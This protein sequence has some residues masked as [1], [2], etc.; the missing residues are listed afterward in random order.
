MMKRQNISVVVVGCGVSG[1]TCG[2]RL[3][4]RGFSDVTII[5]RDLSPNTTSDVAG[6]I[7]SDHDFCQGDRTL[8][9]A[10]I[11]LERFYRLARTQEECGVSLVPFTKLFG[12][13]EPDPWWRLGAEWR[14]KLPI[15]GFHRIPQANLPPG[16]EDGYAMEVP[17]IEMP[18]YM[19]WLRTLFEQLGGVVRQ[20]AI[21]ALSDLYQEDRLI[22]NC[23]GL[24]A[25]ELVGD[26]EVY[27]IRGQI[28][29]VKASD[30]KQWVAVERGNTLTYIFPRPQSNDC[31][32]GGTAEYNDWTMEVNSQTAGEILD[33]CTRLTQPF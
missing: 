31:V 25:R 14:N 11:A 16:Y 2:I 22:V 24:G 10:T 33:R 12:N 23:A 32:L 29:I 5:A 4:E 7:W 30:I 15:R 8:Q 28:V 21:V 19:P 13:L 3:L 26:H 20:G 1:L 9:W 6:A 18:I 17:L 27:P